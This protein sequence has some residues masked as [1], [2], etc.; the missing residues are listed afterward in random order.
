MENRLIHVYFGIDYKLV[1]DAIKWDARPETK[2]R[3]DSCRTWKRSEK[4]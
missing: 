1:W 2:I 4:M 3:R